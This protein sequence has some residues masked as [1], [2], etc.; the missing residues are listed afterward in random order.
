M[1]TES[2]NNG[3]KRSYEELEA[4]LLETK[5]KLAKVESLYH[6]LKEEKATESEED[7]ISDLDEDEADLSDPWAVKFLELRAYRIQHGDC[8]VSEKGPNPKLGQWV[9]NQKR[10]YG[11]VKNNKKGVRITPERIIKLDS[12]GM[13]WGKAFPA[14]AS[15]EERFNQLQD[16]QKAMGHCKIPIC[17]KNPS[18]LA[19]G[20]SVQRHEYKRFHK[21]RDSLLSLEQMAKL[22]EIGFSWKGPRV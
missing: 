8:K 5:A 11:N 14:P 10:A 21:G 22:N 18:D 9:T 13:F 17:A 6:V 3:N 2:N 4:D 12:I 19:M 20:V 15:W 1:S 7:T 16:F